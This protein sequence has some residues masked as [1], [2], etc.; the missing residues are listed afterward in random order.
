M[1]L[2]QM[3]IE[4]HSVIRLFRNLVSGMLCVLNKSKSAI[5]MEFIHQTSPGIN[6]FKTANDTDSV[7][8][9]D[10][11]L[12][13][14]ASTPVSYSRCCLFRLNDTDFQHVINAFKDF[15]SRQE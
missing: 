14:Q 5:T 8:I 11:L 7:S 9:S 1:K 2:L 4:R 6:S 15:C 12:Q 10:I 13:V 3:V